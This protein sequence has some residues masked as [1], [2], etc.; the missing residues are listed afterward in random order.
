[1]V[2][3]LENAYGPT[4]DR[5]TK[6]VSNGEL[7]VTGEKRIE[8]RVEGLGGAF[9]YCTLGDPI[10]MDR[11]LTGESL[12]SFEALAGFL[13]HTATSTTLDAASMDLELLEAPGHG[14]L[15]EAV[16]V[17]VWLIY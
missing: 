4:Y 11:L 13:F 12:P 7:V 8:E 15:G 6:S 1:Q 5:I 17:H 2:E 16:G 3:G 9:T 10:D 14:Y